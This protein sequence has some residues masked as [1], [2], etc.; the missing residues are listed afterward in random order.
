MFSLAF[1]FILTT[2]ALAPSVMPGA[3]PFLKPLTIDTDPENM[4][5]ADATV[6]VRNGELKTVFDIYDFVVVGVLNETHP[7]CPAPTLWATLK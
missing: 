1:A 5:P 6:R 3:L 7:Q 2:L 4:L